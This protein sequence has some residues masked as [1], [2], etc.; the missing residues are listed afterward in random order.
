MKEDALT[1]ELHRFKDLEK[2][3]EDLF[4]NEVDQFKITDES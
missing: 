3:F 2:N 1:A 4:K